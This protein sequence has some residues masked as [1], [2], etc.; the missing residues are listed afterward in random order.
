MISSSP[1]GSGSTLNVA[2]GRYAPAAG[3][4]PS[5]ISGVPSTFLASVTV[6][7]EARPP[8]TMAPSA[9]VTS[10][11][12]ATEVT[13]ATSASLNVSLTTVTSHVEVLPDAMDVGTHDCVSD[14]P[15]C[16][17]M[18]AIGRCWI[19]AE[20]NSGSSSICPKYCVG[21]AVTAV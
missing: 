3:E 13:G 21:V 7:G 2:S 4:S 16:W 5:P 17:A 10:S 11:G 1:T 15:P 6:P 8:S 12:P 20:L 18:N 14:T 9:S 19:G